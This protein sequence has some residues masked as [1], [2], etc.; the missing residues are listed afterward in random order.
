[1]L[2]FYET[3]VGI[4]Q[5]GSYTAG[6]KDRGVRASSSAPRADSRSIIAH[7]ASEDTFCVDQIDDRPG[8]RP[9]W[10][11]ITAG[12]PRWDPQHVPSPVVER[13]GPVVC[14]AAR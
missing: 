14:G 5:P 13:R 6:A 11:V 8:G 1:M 7:Q 2:D 10:Q 12:S 9:D 4:V 3:A